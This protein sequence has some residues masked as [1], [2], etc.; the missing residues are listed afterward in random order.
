[1]AADLGDLIARILL[2]SKEFTDAMKGVEQQ[3]QDTAEKASANLQGLNQGLGSIAEAAAGLGA[4]LGLSHLIGEVADYAAE[5]R[6]LQGAFTALTGSSTEAKDV[7]SELSEIAK[8]SPFE[9]K[10]VAEAAKNM[11][12]LGVSTET[13]TK[14]IQGIVDATAALKLGPEA[15]GRISEA[16]ALM[17]AR[18]EVTTRSMLTLAKTGIDGWKMLAD[19]LGTTVPAAMDMVKTHALSVQDTINAIADGME[20]NF[21]GAA[22]RAAATWKGTWKNIEEGALEAGAAIMSSVTDVMNK[23]AP[24][25]A[26]LVTMMEHLADAWKSLP[27]PVKDAAAAI[28]IAIGVVTTVIGLIA[29]GAAAWAGLTTAVGAAAG[30]VG[31]AI[32]PFLAIAAAVAGVIAAMVLLGSWISAHWSGITT[33]VTEAWTG[34]KELW[35]DYWDATVAALTIAWGYIQRAAETVIGPVVE[36]VKDVWTGIKELWTGLWDL[37]IGAVTLYWKALQASLSIF[38]KILSYLLPFWEPVKEVF[39]KAWNDITGWLT[40]AWEKLRAS[41]EVVWKAIGKVTDDA[42]DKQVAAAKQQKDAISKL[43][44]DYDKAAGQ[45]GIKTTSQLTTAYDAAVNALNAMKKANDAAVAS[46]AARISSDKDMEAAQLAVNKAR[47]DMVE[48]DKSVQDAH[49][50]SAAAATKAAAE[51]DAYQKKIVAADEKLQ[52]SAEK[53]DAM[54][55]KAMASMRNQVVETVKITVSEFDRLGGTG[56]PV[57]EA[58]KRFGEAQYALK[59]LGVTST[60]ALQQAVHDAENWAAKVRDAFEHGQA[61]AA[62]YGAALAAL[63]EKQQALKDYTERDLVGAIKTLGITTSESLQK[64]ADDTEKAYNVLAE[65]GKAT[66]DDLYNGWQKV[67]DAQQAVADN[68]GKE[69]SDAYHQMGLKTTKE[70][71][72]IAKK[73]KDSYDQIAR[74][75]GVG[76]QAELKARVEMLEALKAQQERHG[77]TWSKEDQKQLDDAEKRLKNYSKKAKDAW[78]DL[79]KHIEDIGKK[80]KNDVL[81]KMF[82]RLFGP[83]QNAA[84]KKQEADLSASLDTR[85]REW[86]TYVA[87]NSQKMDALGA[88]YE[89][90]MQKQEQAT[91]DALAGAAKDYDDYAAAVVE[92]IAEIQQ[93]HADQ[94]AEEIDKAQDALDKKTRAYDDYAADVAQNIQEIKQKYAEQL[95][96]ETEKLHNALRDR[97]ESYHD[98]V[99]D[100]NKSLARLGQDTATNIADETEDTKNNIADRTTDYNRYAEDTAKKIAAVREKNKGVYSSEEADLELSLRRKKEDLDAYTAEQNLKLDRYIRDQQ[101]REARE[102]SDLHDS[103][104][105]KSRD[106][107][108]FLQQNAQ[109]Q[110]DAVTHYQ[111]GL[112]KEIG[113][114]TDAL[115][116]KKQDLDDATAATAKTIEQIGIDHA[117]EQDAEIK[118]QQE[119]LAQK[120]LDYDQ[121][122]ADILAKS[123]EQTAGIKADYDKSAGDLTSAL[124]K[125]K[126]DYASFVTDITGPGGKLDQLKAQ[127]TTLW[128]DIQGLATGAMSE[129]GKSILH[130]ASDEVMGVL[131]GKSLSLKGIWD[132]L[133]SVVDGVGSSASKAAGAIPGGGDTPGVP[134]TGGGGGAGGMGSA[135]S[136]GLTGWISAISGAVTAISSVIGNF[137]MAHME[138]SLNAIEH[139]TRYT[140]MYVGERA[141]GGILG[142]LFK[143]DEEL[144][145]GTH[146]KATEN[147]R[148]LFQDWTGVVNPIFTAIQGALDGIAPYVVDTKVA[149]EDIRTLVGSINLA[150]TTASAVPR[151]ITVNVSPQGLTTAEAARALGN[152][153]ASNL[154]SQLV[155]VQ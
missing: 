128:T 2:D 65:S 68:A 106:Y 47:K 15:V 111:E 23:L 92:N 36:F 62:D 152:Q 22:A 114:Q 145:W 143:I 28:G 71:D 99:D 137:Q 51:Y 10:T 107:D 108:E 41:A 20:K 95:E 119:A 101:L 122:V 79:F 37:T 78:G 154:A 81:D 64:A 113:K 147:L 19:S 118:K 142:V 146:T 132:D 14:A 129:I 43:T 70:L 13:A 91:S 75:A 86:D 131:K 57:A 26:P 144:A 117:K 84:L 61:S 105:R 77:E 134:D 55:G 87:E 155:A 85:A 116:K 5:L 127:H 148:D 97:T 83:D 48:G 94:A 100:A 53:N 135:V 31:L 12:L 33:A 138:T 125:E 30:A 121:H 104:D 4:A 74:D 44:D 88:G 120:K 112:D 11:L 56:N 39:V 35:G 126:A 38:D 66:T 98:F 7:L 6:K 69:L 46:G 1:M 42:V 21:G 123:A 136:G 63:K 90:A 60:S 124:E 52:A 29:G 27:G 16:L 153:I 110:D 34:L 102:E 89:A 67:L 133:K 3:A 80:F 140:M 18:G 76:S 8:A 109:D 58:I 115:A 151:T 130:V 72:E 17:S 93:K 73:S 141:D 96:E 82:D 49:A 50:K 40:G 150:A 139:N 45:L 59:Q 9:F 25:L 149:L 32:A 103:L 54:F 24:L